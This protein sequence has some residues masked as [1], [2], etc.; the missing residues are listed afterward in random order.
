VEPSNSFGKGSKLSS[1]ERKVVSERSEVGLHGVSPVCELT[2]VRQSRAGR[3]S[4]H[5]V[6]YIA[7]QD[8][9]RT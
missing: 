1:F 5:A 9:K 4:L 7:K 8:Q 3:Q 6:S 2:G